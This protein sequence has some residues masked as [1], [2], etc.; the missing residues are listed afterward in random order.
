MWKPT[1]KQHLVNKQYADAN[2]GG[3]GSENIFLVTFTIDD[4]SADVQTFS[5]D[6]T[7]AEILEAAS[8]GKL[9]IAISEVSPVAHSLLSID[10]NDARFIYS[11]FSINTDSSTSEQTIHFTSTMYDLSSDGTVTETFDEVTLPVT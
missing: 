6:K 9:V 7:V 1:K 4:L 3:S 8:A 11:S 10:E 2:G 5:A